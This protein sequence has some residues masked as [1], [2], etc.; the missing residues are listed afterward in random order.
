MVQFFL[1]TRL[2]FSDV[3]FNTLVNTCATMKK[4]TLT[5][6]MYAVSVHV[7]GYNL[8]SIFWYLFQ[9]HQSKPATVLFIPLFTT[10]FTSHMFVMLLRLFT[11]CDVDPDSETN[12]YT[13]S[14]LIFFLPTSASY[15]ENSLSWTISSMEFEFS[16]Y[17][18]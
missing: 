10:I 9:Y 17:L 15:P 8:P 7:T 14:L 16:F 12:I 18:Y 13:G 5:Y 4:H 2:Y 6:D 11:I 3:K 1:S